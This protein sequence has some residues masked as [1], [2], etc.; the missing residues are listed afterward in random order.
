[1]AT[2]EEVV[3]AGEPDHS[4]ADDRHARPAHY[5]RTPELVLTPR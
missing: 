4:P 5:P 2:L 1:M 3:G